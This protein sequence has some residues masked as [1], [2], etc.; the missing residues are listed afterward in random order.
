MQRKGMGFALILITMILLCMSSAS[1][2][3]QQDWNQQCINKT[4]GTTTLYQLDESG[5]PVAIGSIPGGTYVK[6]TGYYA[7]GNMWSI[8][9]YSGGGTASGM[10]DASSLTI[11]VTSVSVDGGDV[12]TVPEALAGNWEAI[13]AYLNGMYS[14]QTF[15]ST[16]SGVRVEREA[17]YSDEENGYVDKPIPASEIMAVPAELQKI[18]QLGSYWT[19]IREN[20]EEKRVETSGINFSDEIEFNQQIAVIHATRTGVATMHTQPTIKSGV[21]GKIGTGTVVAVLKR[22]HKYSRIFVD[23]KVGCVLNDTLVYLPR[24]AFPLEEGVITYKGRKIR[25]ED[26]NVRGGASAK[27]RVLEAWPTGLVVQ[28]WAKDGD[29]YEIEAYGMRAFINQ[30]FLTLN[31]EGGSTLEGRFYESAAMEP[32]DGT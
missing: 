32:A 29:F 26:I 11:A 14:N 7:A 15:Y 23:G 20:G 1:A 17:G 21:L 28:V 9:Y 27:S 25:G 18:V 16:G 13:A 22:G 12:E 19:I 31:S 10:I 24:Y 6:Q 8:S 4:T 3:S 5:N 2:L 30:K